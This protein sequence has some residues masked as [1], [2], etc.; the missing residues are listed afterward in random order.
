M[1]QNHFFR[2][3]QAFV[4]RETRN[5]LQKHIFTLPKHASNDATNN[6]LAP[7]WLLMSSPYFTRNDVGSLAKHY[8]I[9][10]L[11]LLKQAKCGPAAVLTHLCAASVL[12]VLKGHGCQCSPSNC[13]IL[14][15][16]GPCLYDLT[17]QKMFNGNLK[18]L[19]TSM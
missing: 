11:K 10:M 6:E 16:H 2:R 15:E 3:V 8:I 4:L 5:I 7:S 17:V 14:L 19:N 9:N 18:L 1:F 12:E 13:L